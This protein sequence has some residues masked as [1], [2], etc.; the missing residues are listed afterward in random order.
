[1]PEQNAARLYK[2][3]QKAHANQERAA[4]LNDPA[5]FIKLAA[6]RGIVL[7]AETLETQISQLSDE[8]VAAI[9]NPGISP[10]RHIFPR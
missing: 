6:A 4:A 1:M 5:A 9:F 3:V 2:D 10:R 7:N 8:E